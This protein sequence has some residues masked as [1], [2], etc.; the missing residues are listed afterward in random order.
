MKVSDFK[1]TL[2][3]NDG[4]FLSSGDFKLEYNDQTHVIWLSAGENPLSI[5]STD[6]IKNRIVHHTSIIEYD[7]KKWLRLYWTEDEKQFVDISITDLVQVYKFN[8]GLLTSYVD[9]KWQ[10]DIDDT[11]A[12]T[13]YA[14]AINSRADTISA[15]LQTEVER[16]KTAEEINAAAINNEKIRAEGAESAN[17]IAISNE[18]S[19]AEGV[20]GSLQ[21]Q[22]NSVSV[23]L[24]AE[25]EAR[26]NADNKITANVNVVSSDVISL[27]TYATELS[28][29]SPDNIGIIAT[30][31]NSITTL[32]SDIVKELKFVNHIRIGNDT[33]V[34]TIAAFFEK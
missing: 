26:E 14:N 24:T 17:A 6:F 23:D 8:D 30:L 13:T 25:V 20:E 11:I 29:S 15:S 31:S 16:A 1:T 27:K 32:Q 12:R 33:P 2:I 19:R 18:E 4:K 10:V 28:G 34:T 21:A 22:I 3:D 7:G 5:D 9:N